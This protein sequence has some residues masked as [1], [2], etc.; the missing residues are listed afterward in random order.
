[1]SIF[2]QPLSHF[3]NPRMSF[4][5]T[6]EASFWNGPFKEDCVR[7][8]EFPWV[9]WVG[10]YLIAANKWQLTNTDTLITK[11]NLPMSCTT[12]LLTHSSALKFSCLLLQG[13]WVHFLFLI[14]IV[15]NKLFVACLICPMQFFFD[16]LEKSLAE[17]WR[18]WVAGRWV[19]KSFSSV[20]WNAIIFQLSMKA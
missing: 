8:L 9:G 16:I 4:A 10:A 17:I 6:W 15:L 11:T 14:A 1:M 5:K 2:S 12:F 3:Y 7:I 13:S 18:R 20:L 19:R